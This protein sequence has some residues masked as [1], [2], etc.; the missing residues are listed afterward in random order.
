[1][2]K[3]TFKEGIELLRTVGNKPELGDYDDLSTENESY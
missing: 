1:M 2:V 3:I